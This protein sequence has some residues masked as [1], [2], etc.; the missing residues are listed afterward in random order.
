M[1]GAL[2]QGNVKPNSSESGMYDKE[3][4][5]PALTRMWGNRDPGPLLVGCQL[6][7][8]FWKTAQKQMNSVWFTS[9]TS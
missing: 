4:E 5:Q 2:H 1:K 7:Q 6:A 8:T 9:S 3:Q